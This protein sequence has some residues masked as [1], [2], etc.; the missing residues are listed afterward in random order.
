MSESVKSDTN[1]L[2]GLDPEQRPTVNPYR[3][4]ANLI[5]YRLRWDLNWKSWVCRQRLKRLRN[6]HQGQK[7]II[8]GN[9]PSLNKVDFS[10]LEKAGVFT[11]GLNKINLLFERTTFRPNCIV[12]MNRHVLEQNR[13]FYNQTEIPLFLN[14]SH[15]RQIRLRTNVT[16]LNFTNEPRKFARNCSISMTQGHTVTYA[17]LQLAF[18]MG[19]QQV[20]LIGM[21]HDFAAK[22]PG[23]ITVLAGKSDPDHFHPDYFAEGVKWQLPDYRSMEVHYELARDTYERYGR[24]VF[25]CTEG[26]K[27]EVFERRTLPHFLGS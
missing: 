10:I 14:S 5:L 7:A 13:A 9:G 24:K 6:I 19:F 2:H 25:N 1:S 11:F 4:S 16:F 15:R 17:A 27:L 18:H 20:G 3:F 8:I 23:N 12:S 21:D 26:G 22:G